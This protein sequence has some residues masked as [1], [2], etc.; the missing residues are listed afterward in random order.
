MVEGSYWAL[1]GNIWE[2]N[3]FP[4]TLKC[5]GQ[6]Q[7]LGG[8]EW[9]I[10]HVWLKY[11]QSP[12]GRAALGAAPGGQS[13]IPAG[14]GCLWRRISILLGC[15]HFSTSSFPLEMVPW[16]LP[17]PS[18]GSAR[19]AP[20]SFCCHFSAQPKERTGTETQ[21]DAAASPASGRCCSS[22]S[23]LLVCFKFSHLFCLILVSFIQLAQSKVTAMTA[24]S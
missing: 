10:V 23:R 2:E 12:R 24:L 22:S 8:T 7:C 21:I 6:E 5:A 4:C 9:K 17:A 11:T 13:L 16:L 18:W 1:S 15:F 14:P 3:N 19:A 20:S